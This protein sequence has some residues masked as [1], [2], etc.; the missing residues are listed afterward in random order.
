MVGQPTLILNDGKLI[1]PHMDREG[2]TR[3][4][5]MTA[6]RRAGV[7]PERLKLEVTESA[8]MSDPVTARTVLRELDALGCEISIDDFGTGYSSLAY[9]AD[10]PVSEVKID[11]SFVSRMSA[12]SSEKIIVNSTIDLAHHLQLRAVAEEYGTDDAQAPFVHDFVAAW[13]KVMNLDR[14]D[15]A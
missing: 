12:G 5:V 15:L 3:D 4:Q 11:R 2:V 1:Q 7:P 13:D 9:L 6:L 10:L 14:F 8:L